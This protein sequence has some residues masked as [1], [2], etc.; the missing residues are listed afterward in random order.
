MWRG[1]LTGAL[2][3]LIACSGGSATGSTPLSPTAEPSSPIPSPAPTI[4]A[5]K[6]IPDPPTTK[7]SVC[8]DAHFW[9]AF[10]KDAESGSYDQSQVNEELRALL[11]KL[12]RDV[13]AAGGAS[14]QGAL[15]E[16]VPAGTAVLADNVGSSS[17]RLD[18][19]FFGLDLKTVLKYLPNCQ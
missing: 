18:L 14:T 9:A 11:P 3:L 16:L 13:L 4:A 19:A 5:P 17:W 1:L 10:I 15:A 8:E 6:S 12:Q 7:T 2:S